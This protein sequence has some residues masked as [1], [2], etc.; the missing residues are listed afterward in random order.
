MFDSSSLRSDTQ[1]SAYRGGVI[2]R[3]RRISRTPCVVLVS[4]DKELL[5]R[6]RTKAFAPEMKVLVC[7]VGSE[8]FAI[9]RIL[10]IKWRGCDMHS[11]NP[12]TSVAKRAFFSEDLRLITESVWN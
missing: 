11:N 5:V 7:W 9:V 12:L 3:R 4:P 8:C 1:V 10:M 2:N 6:Q